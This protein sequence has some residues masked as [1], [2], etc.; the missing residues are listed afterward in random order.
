[1]G[2]RVLVV[3]DDPTVS[4]VVCRY[5][6]RAGYDVSMAA[7]GAAALAVVAR[8][9]P[10]LV[11][12]DLML[13]GIDGL[14]VCRRLRTRPDGVPIVMLTALGEEADRVLGLQLGADDYV[15]KPFSPR[16]LVLRVQSVLRRAGADAAPSA[17]PLRDGDLVVDEVRRVAR[18][19]EAEL[20]LTVR[21]F[22]LLAFLMRHPG[23]AFRRADL[24]ERVWGWHIGDQSTVT[25]HVRRLREKVEDDPARPR[26]IVTVWGVGYR[27]EPVG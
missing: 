4:D 1:M 19:R 15:T 12:L 11:V 14:E 5:L 8:E 9:M 27:Y 26:R 6:R 18:L 10:D 20:T 25:V 21:E 7:D 16:E 3:G 23:Q 17:A 2:Q 13:P 24:L 22:D